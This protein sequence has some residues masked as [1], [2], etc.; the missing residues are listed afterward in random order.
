MFATRAEA[1]AFVRQVRRAPG[2]WAE[3][4]RKRK[5]GWTV[6]VVCLS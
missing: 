2:L 3:V 1:R 4:P 5:R 6:R